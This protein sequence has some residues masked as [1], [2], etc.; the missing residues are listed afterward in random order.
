MSVIKSSHRQESKTICHVVLQKVGRIFNVS[1]IKIILIA[2]HLCGLQNNT[3][4]LISP[5]TYMS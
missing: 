1:N 5:I 4:G 3:E 2:P